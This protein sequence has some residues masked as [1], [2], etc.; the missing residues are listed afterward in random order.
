MLKPPVG[1]ILMPNFDYTNPLE[2]GPY[3]Q[4]EHLDDKFADIENLFDPDMDDDNFDA[5]QFFTDDAWGPASS[6]L[7]CISTGA[8][9]ASTL[10]TT[11]T[12][13]M[14]GETFMPRVGDLAGAPD[15]LAGGAAGIEGADPN[16]FV[17]ANRV[18]DAGAGLLYANYERKKFVPGSVSSL[19]LRVQL[20]TG[21]VPT[22]GFKTVRLGYVGIDNITTSITHNTGG[23]YNLGEEVVT[24]SDP[25]SVMNSFYDFTPPGSPLNGVLQPVIYTETAN[26]TFAS[27]TL[28]R[29]SIALYS[30]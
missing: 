22:S 14:T 4:I 29:Y 24:I 18:I 12:V 23:T 28:F 5:S 25:L 15:I 13:I 27:N 2:L 1:E 8:F 10:L 11:P 20:R 9:A 3:S 6:K 30:Y 16:F 26:M 7:V 17:G 19:L 21:P